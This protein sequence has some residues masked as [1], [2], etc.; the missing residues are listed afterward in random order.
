MRERVIWRRRMKS[1]FVQTFVFR[2]DVSHAKLPNAFWEANYF[3]LP[4]DEADM[5]Y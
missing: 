3:Y 2:Q 1:I 4:E 5:I